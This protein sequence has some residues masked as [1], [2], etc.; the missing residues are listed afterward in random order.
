[1][2]RVHH[3]KAAKDYPDHGIK[4]G[5]MYFHWKFRYGGKHRSKVRPRSSQ[6]TQ[7]DF[8]SQMYG[9]QEEI[10]DAI[11][12]LLSADQVV[13]EAAGALGVAAARSGRVRAPDERPLVAV[14]TGANIDAR[15]LARLLAARS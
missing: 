11:V 14:V 9:I 5:E 2:P 3:V 15:V 10:E 4:K 13:A 7:S 6:L 1:M 8:L 12:A